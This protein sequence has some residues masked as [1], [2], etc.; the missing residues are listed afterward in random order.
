MKL[1]FM[2]RRWGGIGIALA[3]SC[4]LLL[5]SQGSRIANAEVSE[6]NATDVPNFT[7]TINPGT[8]TAEGADFATTKFGDSWDMNNAQDIYLHSS[9]YCEAPRTFS[10][11]TMAS[12][13]WSGSSVVPFRDGKQLTSPNF[14]LLFPGYRGG[15]LLGRDGKFDGNA[16][17]TSI[18]YKLTL[19]MYIGDVKQP[20]GDP[21]PWDT[22]RL[23][24][25]DGDLGDFADGRCAVSNKIDPVQGWN[26]YQIDLR[27]LGSNNNGTCSNPING[28]TGNVTGLRVMPIA[29]R[30]SVEVKVDWARLTGDAGPTVPIQWANSGS[31]ISLYA[32]T[33]TTAGNGWLMPIVTNQ[34]GAAGSLNWDASRLPPG[35]Y[36]IYGQ[37]GSDYAGLNLNNPWDMNQAGDVIEK[38]GINTSFAGGVMT[39]ATTQGGGYI[40]LN[41]DQTKPINPATFNRLTFRINVQQAG[42]HFSV[43]WQ[44]SDDAWVE[45]VSNQA[46]TGTGWT[47]VTV[48]LSGNAKWANGKSKKN[49]R[50]LPAVQPSVNFQLDWVGMTASATPATENE[51]AAESSYSAQPVIVKGAPILQFTAPSM[52]SGADYAAESLNNPWDFNSSA[53]LGS[54]LNLLNESY[55]NGIYKSDSATVQRACNESST[56]GVWGEPNLN[57]EMGRPVDSSRFRYLTFRMKLTGVQ[58]VGWGWVSRVYFLQDGYKNPA[59]PNEPGDHAITNDIVIY[60][61]WN[62]Y[63]IDMARSDLYDDEANS[64]STWTSILPTLIRFDPHEIPHSIP[65]T[66]EMDSITLRAKD[67]ADDTYT[68]GWTLDNTTGPVTTTLY[69]SDQ[70]PGRSGAVQSVIATLTGGEVSYQWNTSAVAEGEYYLRAVV[71]DEYNSK[72]WWSDAPLII[73][74]IPRIQFTGTSTVTKVARG[75]ALAWNMNTLSDLD[76]GDLGSFTGLTASAGAVRGTT[77]GNLGQAYFGLNLSGKTIDPTIFTKMQVI[78]TTNWDRKSASQFSMQYRDMD[79]GT[80]IGGWHSCNSLT[81]AGTALHLEEGHTIYTVDLAKCPGWSNGRPK[82]QFRYLPAI[83][84][85]YTFAVDRIS[86]FKPGSATYTIQWN[87]VTGT[88]RSVDAEKL[89]ISLYYDQNSSGYDGDLIASGQSPS[90]NYTWDVSALGDGLYYVYAEAYNHVSPP[91]S[92]YAT[93]TLQIGLLPADYP[94]NVYTPTIQR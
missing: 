52:T 10:N 31:R 70:A 84:A 24:W 80:D 79:I 68:I 41:V 17:D 4:V 48:D 59:L 58:D 91:Q 88:G 19:R 32:D 23:M 94:Y 89:E 49:F 8:A 28:W 7:I 75:T 77:A 74:R 72:E 56:S 25:T 71:S 2:G 87:N 27:T 37:S 55:T 45:G 39:G 12:G 11:V 76:Q 18:Y 63:T 13:I 53:D 60:E 33:D 93:G 92:L 50:L 21:Q 16:I 20:P 47:N 90:G 22:V 78:Q 83:P 5:A 51:L 81:D 46:H 85:N 43:W 38:G 62:D 66:F 26:T 44:D 86:I 29:D 35:S 36:Y 30:E 9:P 6:P 69:Y 1:I 67:V 40:N 61:G 54:T 73:D 3:I 15:L 57:M 64:Y 82:N 65:T 34:N 14:W 42:K